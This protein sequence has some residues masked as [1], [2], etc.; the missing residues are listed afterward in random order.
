MME[1]MK[2]DMEQREQDRKD[3]DSQVKAITSMMK[4]EVASRDADLREI[5]EI[6]LN[7]QQP[8]QPPQIGSATR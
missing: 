3:F 4:A 6:I 2:M 1:A 5:K 7:L 8:P